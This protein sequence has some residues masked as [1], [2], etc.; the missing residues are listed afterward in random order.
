M[1]VAVHVA[2][3]VVVT[4]GHGRDVLAH[5]LLGA[6]DELFHRVNETAPAESFEQSTNMLGRLA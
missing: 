4:I 5:D 2:F 3:G 6:R 1:T